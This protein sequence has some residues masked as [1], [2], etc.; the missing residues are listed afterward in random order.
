MPALQGPFVS[1]FRL[2]HLNEDPLPA[3][4][5]FS[6]GS[7]PEYGS[8]V[9][10]DTALDTA[11]EDASYVTLSHNRDT[12]ARGVVTFRPL[13]DP[14]IPADALA[15]VNYPTDAQADYVHL[16]FQ[17]RYQSAPRMPPAP[18]SVGP[19]PEVLMLRSDFDGTTFAPFVGRF[20]DNARDDSE[21]AWATTWWDETNASNHSG[22]IPW[23]PFALF[24]TPAFLFDPDQYFFLTW[25]GTSFGDPDPLRENAIFVS[26]LVGQVTWYRLGVGWH[27]VGGHSGNPTGGPNLRILTPGVGWVE[28]VD[29]PA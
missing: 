29:G 27:K 3:A 5:V 18:S 16:Q 10:D 8:V 14:P 12:G 22:P 2:R 19:S 28:V 26:Q 17:V 15:Y 25:V 21:D 4:S 20:A 6:D 7:T 11:D 23:T 24:G 13:F 9:G 1:T